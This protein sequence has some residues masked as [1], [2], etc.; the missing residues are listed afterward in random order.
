MRGSGRPANGLSR[1]RSTSS[2]GR[3]SA[4]S[5]STRSASAPGSSRPL[6]RLKRLRHVRA[7]QRGDGLRRQAFEQQAEHRLRARDP[8][9]GGGEVALLHLGRARRVVGGDERD[10]AQRAPER[11]DLVGRP[12]RRRAL[13]ARA[14]RLEVVLGEGQVVRARL[15]RGVARR[16]EGDALA[17]LTCTTCR[18]QPV[19][20]ASSIA[21]SIAS[22]SASD[23]ARGD[24]VA[25]AACPARLAQ[26]GRP[27]GVDE[28]G[29]AERGGARHAGLEHLVVDGREVLD[30]AVAH[31]GLEA[32]DAALGQLVEPVQVAG[33]EP[34]PEREVDHRRRGRRLDLGVER[35]AVDRRRVGVERHLDAGGGAAGRER[36]ACRWPSPP[37]RCGPAR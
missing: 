15:A 2:G 20:S 11:L 31:E 29:Q 5:T 13:R 4:R 27:L 23:G 35:R 9:P 6:G 33:H 22:S 26:G 8:A 12:Q 14:E 36:A 17:L 30:P 32:G 1:W 7:R 24:E 16:H 18:S 28:D 19:R 34:A 37:T 21:T 3:R 10:V 25:P